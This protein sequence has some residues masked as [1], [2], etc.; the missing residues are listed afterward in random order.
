MLWISLLNRNWQDDTKKCINSILKSD[1][2]E[3][4]IFL[5][6]NWSDRDESIQLKNFYKNNDNIIINRV[7]KNIGFTWWNNYNINII[8]KEKDITHIML[9]SNDCLVSNN[10]LKMLMDEIYKI[11]NKWIYGPII[12]SKNG[13]IQAV[14]ANL[15]LRTW[16]SKRLKKITW[17]FNRVDYVT[18]ACMIIPTELIKKI[19]WL[20]DVFFAYREESDFCFRA[21]KLWYDSYA[22]N[23]DWISHKEETA[24]RKKRPYYTYLMFR[25]RIIFLKRH[26][27][28]FQYITSYII[29]L[30]YILIIFPKSFGRKNYKYAI[31]GIVDWIKW[32]WTRELMTLCE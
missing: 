28:L 3:Y 9:L 27:N 16:S 17:K 5:L 32:K 23:I 10:F 14:G 22:M 8:K 26:A 6:D 7:S 31:R 12:R 18:W 30:A 21:K 25:N 11:N 20:D 29:L 13:D 24:T 2:N 15:N 19:W 1:F 4:K